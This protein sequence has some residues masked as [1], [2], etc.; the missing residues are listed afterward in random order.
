MRVMNAQSVK[1]VVCAYTF[2]YTFYLLLLSCVRLTT[3][4]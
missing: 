2:I 4:V 1:Y 3:F